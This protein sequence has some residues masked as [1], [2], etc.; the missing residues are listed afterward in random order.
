MTSSRALQ[1]TLS[2]LAVVAL[3][4]LWWEA[5]RSDPAAPRQA[6]S[7]S[8]FVVVT[9][10]GRQAVTA[11]LSFAPIPGSCDPRQ[12]GWRDARVL[13]PGASARFDTGPGGTEMPPDCAMNVTVQASGGAVAALAVS[14]WETGAM[15]ALP[16]LPAPPVATG[17]MI[18][19]WSLA[20]DGGEG[21]RIALRNVGPEPAAVRLRL[22]DAQGNPNRACDVDCRVQLDSGGG[23][24][25]RL[26]D[27]PG[28]APGSFGSA[29]VES[30]GSVLAAV[31][32][33]S[34][35]DPRGALPVAAPALAGGPGGRDG[36]AW[37]PDAPK[38]AAIVATGLQRQLGGGSA[39]LVIQ[40]GDAGLARLQLQPYLAEGLPASR[41]TLGDVSAGAAQQFDLETQVD[42]QPG[43]RYA[44]VAE[45]L[46]QPAALALL[47]WPEA[48][49]AAA[50]DAPPAAS[51]LILPLAW[52]GIGGRASW[53]SIQSTAA[54][55]DV[56]IELYAAGGGERPLIELRRRIPA[57]A[58]VSIDLEDDAFANA[59]PSLTAW[60]RIRSDNPVAAVGFL[61]DTEAEPQVAAYAARPAGELSE[62]LHAPLFFSG[63]PDPDQQPSA[64]PPPSRT[65]LPPQ[66]PTASPT[67]RPPLGPG[68]VFDRALDLRSQARGSRAVALAVGGDGSVWLR[69]RRSSARDRI[70]RIGADG[71]VEGFDGLAE[72][73]QLAEDRMRRA[74]NMS[75]FWSLDQEGRLWIGA[76]YLQ[77]GNLR[78][79][80]GD[81]TE[82]EGG[83][84]MLDEVVLDAGGRAW[85]P[86]RASI[87]CSRPEGCGQ[88]SLLSFSP[89]GRGGAAIDLGDLRPAGPGS[90]EGL[91]ML[92]A[93][94]GSSGPLLG[95][96]QPAS[97][98]QAGDSA[99]AVTASAFFSLPDAEPIDYPGLGPPQ[100]PAT[101][102]DAGYATASGLDGLG[103]PVVFTW[104][105]AQN[106]AGQTVEPLLRMNTWLPASEDW[107]PPVELLGPNRADPYLDPATDQITAAAWCPGDVLWIGSR[108]GNLARW[109]GSGFA[110]HL[111]P[112]LL[113]ELPNAPVQALACRPDGALL[114]VTQDALLV[115][116]G[117][118][119][120]PPR[121][122][123][124]PFLLTRR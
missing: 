42:L 111:R 94:A 52:R 75:G 95:G 47:R 66:R 71:S 20:R 82:P 68:A 86:R 5:P 26:E 121:R 91:R 4:L 38:Q 64:T 72:M 92:S 10:P 59:G 57:N 16:A 60:L 63:R 87:D 46:G 13:E 70:L 36:R 89:Q 101:L 29:I 123:L 9:N 90:I 67:A 93:R 120:E 2:G 8:A 7:A 23:T 117:G 114:I 97:Q 109:T 96:S 102:R 34:G 78:Q 25:W 24:I 62:I 58:S 103:R 12:R 108:R 105:E 98:D 124:L 104:I 106:P 51:E 37:L 112:G 11:A 65:P 40:A 118:E 76:R 74:G 119:I 84:V 41:F 69:L 31:A 79:L 61:A 73:L 14:R 3:A 19:A 15:S 45:A 22:L 39:A 18:P 32:A 115:Y 56:S 48:K 88:S 44:V 1:T 54:L 50:Y 21:S 80:A 122:I 107:L 83:L 55:A 30:S 27:L 77:D 100:A 6:R 85:V 113:P 116:S 35:L 99:W 53:L 28:V 17:Q 81:Q 49:T 43:L 33:R 110:E